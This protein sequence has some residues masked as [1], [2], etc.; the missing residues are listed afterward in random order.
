M[1]FNYLFALYLFQSSSSSSWAVVVNI[2]PHRSFYSVALKIPV[3]K[4]LWNCE[5][6]G[7]W[8]GLEH[9]NV[10]GSTF[11]F[12]A[13]LNNISSIS[14]CILLYSVWTE[15]PPS[16]SR[17]IYFKFMFDI[18]CHVLPW[19]WNWRN[20]FFPILYTLLVFLTSDSLKIFGPIA[21]GALLVLIPVNSSG[22]TLFFLQ[23]DLVVSNI[24]KL[25]IS[26]IRPKSY[27]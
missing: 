10:T 3:I 26:N 17:Q 7:L 13:R 4:F 9:K 15:S 23:R 21:I 8:V 6:F 18:M 25:S 2:H 16:V 12:L 27:K 22:G 11:P 24:D 19:I 5:L 1:A 14:V 20:F